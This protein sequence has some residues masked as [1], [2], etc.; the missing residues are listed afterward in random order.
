MSGLV[1]TLQQVADARNIVLVADGAEQVGGVLF[2]VWD[3]GLV[4]WK[5]ERR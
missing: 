3:D 1:G 5:R 4:T 2:Y